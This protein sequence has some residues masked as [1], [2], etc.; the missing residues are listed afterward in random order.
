MVAVIEPLVSNGF[1]TNA[2]F[3]PLIF[4]SA[5]LTALYIWQQQTNLFKHGNKIPGPTALPFLGNIHELAGV[6]NAG[7]IMQKALR[8][9][10]PYQ[11]IV[12]IWLGSKLIVFL[13]EPKD[14]EVIL[15]SSVHLDKSTEYRM[16]QP[17]FGDGLLISS[18]HLHDLVVPA[19]ILGAYRI[20]C[21]A[22]G[23]ERGQ[24]ILMRTN[25]ELLE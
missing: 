18:E 14:V 23:L 16:F 9:A 15:S 21:E 2:V 17:W 8:I 4:I 24:L 11:D 3:Y 10:K 20:I 6:Q 5:A 19:S 22:L 1:L 12:K 13:V 7:E 25:E